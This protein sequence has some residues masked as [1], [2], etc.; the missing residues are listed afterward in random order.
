MPDPNRL[1]IE[2]ARNLIRAWDQQREQYIQTAR[3]APTE[4]DVAARRAARVRDAQ[5]RLRD[6]VD[7]HDGFPDGDG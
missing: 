4:Q 5:Q 2:A 7:F 1:V 3:N 6:A